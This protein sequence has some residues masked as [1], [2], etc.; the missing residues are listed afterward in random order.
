ME[1][2]SKLYGQ[3]TAFPCRQIILPYREPF[4]WDH[5]MESLS[6]TPSFAREAIIP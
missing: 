5:F 4:P 3:N 2:E 6:A 1:T